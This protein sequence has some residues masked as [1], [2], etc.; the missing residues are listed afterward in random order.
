[1]FMT[2]NGH[3]LFDMATE[4]RLPDSDELNKYSQYDF[5]MAISYAIHKGKP[6]IANELLEARAYGKKTLF[7]SLYNP[8]TMTGLK[9]AFLK[10]SDSYYTYSSKYRA[11]LEKFLKIEGFANFL[12]FFEFQTLRSIFYFAISRGHTEIVKLLLAIPAVEAQTYARKNAALRNAASYGNP[13]VVK[14]LLAIPAVAANAH[15]NENEALRNAASYGNPEVVKLLLAIPAVAA[16]AHA[17]ENAALREAASFGHTEVVKLLLAIPAVAANA[18]ANE[19]AALREAASF[20]HTEVVKLLLAIPAVA[21]NAHANE[22]AALREAASFGHTEVVKLLLAIPAVAANA[23]ANENNTLQWV[24]QNGYFK[25]YILL[26]TNHSFTCASLS[27]LENSGYTTADQP[28]VYAQLLSLLNEPQIPHFLITNVVEGLCNYSNK[29]ALLKKNALGYKE[30][31][32]ELD[33]LVGKLSSI[34]NLAMGPLNKSEQTKLIEALL[35]QLS[36]K[37]IFENTVITYRDNQYF[38]TAP[39]QNEINLS[40]LIENANLSHL[41]LSNELI[42]KIGERLQEVLKFWNV[43]K[44]KNAIIN[45]LP[46]SERAPIYEY[47]GYAYRNINAFFRSEPL[48]HDH[49]MNDSNKQYI[50]HANF[51]IGCLLNNAV[52]KI[53]GLA[54][55]HSTGLLSDEIKKLSCERT[56]LD[57]KEMLPTEVLARRTANPMVNI[58][59]VMSF[60]IFEK[61]SQLI[62]RKKNIH[63]KLDNGRGFNI[64]TDEGEILYPHGSQFITKKVR[65]D[66]FV[67]TQVCSPTLER[68]H[69]WSKIA[70]NYAWDNHLSKPYQEATNKLTF[71]NTNVYRPNHSLPHTFRVM[72]LTG[73]VANYFAHFAQDD[74]FKAFC[75]SLSDNE[76]EWLRIGAAFSVTGRESEISPAENPEK[77]GIYR[78]ASADNFKQFVKIVKPSGADTIAETMADVMHYMGHPDYETMINQHSDEVERKRRNFFNRILS[79][80]HKIDLVRCYNA[81]EFSNMMQSYQELSTPSSEQ[82]QMLNALV[83]FNIQLIKAQGNKLKCDIQPDGTYVDADIS[84][85]PIFAEV[86]LSLKRLNEVTDTVTRPL[87]T[88]A[89]QFPCQDENLSKRKSDS[90]IFSSAKRQKTTS[91]KNANPIE[92]NS[93]Q[94]R[95]FKRQEMPSKRKK[96][97]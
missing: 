16:N 73:Y 22:N 19:N 52:N 37:D 47:V 80:A 60:S 43:A 61:G 15:A 45:L 10:A 26:M 7:S 95:I 94:E 56:F 13:E 28:N 85:Q 62:N 25:A 53:P 75:Q 29:I 96:I 72:L 71:D 14:L 34:D 30:Q 65:D 90:L 1:M 40:V 44:G 77:Y 97:S 31:R 54:E 50:N 36:Q 58:N 79:V 92:D 51:L 67:S 3:A 27:K 39:S 2:Q 91:T 70:L 69:Y 82:Y 21:A 38:L 81:D 33:N 78:R 18:H 8:I 35:E 4:G 5:N 46:P 83:H 17:N 89:F 66:Y 57:R 20:G 88:L 84:Y 55:E 93:H 32:E 41:T 68:N 6:D 42:E 12:Y 59:A 86:G 74:E 11:T 64:N 63:T 76:M 48:G 87:I 24:A 49:I 23:H 9:D